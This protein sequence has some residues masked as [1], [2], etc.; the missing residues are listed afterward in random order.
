[1]LK[2]RSK[3]AVCDISRMA[4]GPQAEQGDTILL[5]TGKALKVSIRRMA[6]LDFCVLELPSNVTGGLRIDAETAPTVHKMCRKQ[7]SGEDD[8]GPCL[9]LAVRKLTV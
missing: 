8:K 5:D 1:M 4:L 7:G 6:V 3:T 2:G 9:R